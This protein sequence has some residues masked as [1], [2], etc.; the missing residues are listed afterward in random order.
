MNSPII[1]LALFDIV[2]QYADDIESAKVKLKSS[3]GSSSPALVFCENF[4]AQFFQNKLGK[5]IKRFNL[6]AKREAIAC[7]LDAKERGAPVAVIRLIT[8]FE[9]LCD[10]YPS[11]LALGY[12]VG[13]KS[14]IS[15]FHRNYL[16]T[17]LKRIA[18]WSR[19]EDNAPLTE[20]ANEAISRLTDAFDAAGI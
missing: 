17:L 6:V 19:V 1:A 7:R 3:M 8:W 18:E 2:V 20:C 11:V 10:I 9:T 4:F 14:Q 12:G 15:D 16:L 5:E 13:S